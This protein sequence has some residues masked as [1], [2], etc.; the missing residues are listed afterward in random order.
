MA[1]LGGKPTLTFV[2]RITVSQ[3]IAFTRKVL[4]TRVTVIR[5][6]PFKKRDD[7]LLTP[8]QIGI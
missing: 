8:T 2:D 7:I 4:S 6:Q 3:K 5:L 1:E